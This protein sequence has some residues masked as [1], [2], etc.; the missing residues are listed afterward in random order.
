MLSG[1]RARQ[2]AAV[3][4][5]LSLVAFAA[6]AD[7]Q[8]LP[9]V[10]TLRCGTECANSSPAVADF[11]PVPQFPRDNID[12]Y[13]VFVEGYVK[14]QYTIQ[15]DGHVTDIAVL[16]VVGP[17]NFVAS[18]LNTVKSWTYKPALLDGKPVPTC[19]TLLV[20]FRVP[21]AQ[22]EGR[23]EIASLYRRA[24]SQIKDGKLEEAKITLDEGQATP[25]LNFYERGMLANLSSM[26]ALGQ[27]D[28]FEARRLSQLATDHGADELKPAIIRNLFETR[29]QA[30]LALGDV[31][32]VM[33][34]MKR[35]ER[36]PGHD[37]NGPISKLVADSLKKVDEATA[38]GTLARIP[39]A[40]RGDGAFV[41]LYRRNFSFTEVSGSLSRFTLACQQSAVQSQITTAAEWHVP[42]N[43]ND[44]WIL[45]RGTPG[46]TFKLVQLAD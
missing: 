18:A 28:Y 3:G 5:A 4:L 45:V 16:E 35:L 40:D 43:W 38:F 34:T 29:I 10:R 7:D 19:R 11:H 33:G 20:T 15:P 13:G 24:V 32:D 14:L 31:V 30:S 8:D 41:F 6:R 39:A 25:K 27:K 2:S 44:C 1:R 12:W 46:T 36:V 42:K 9:E 23:A 37:P 26:V 21:N 22:P 17:Q